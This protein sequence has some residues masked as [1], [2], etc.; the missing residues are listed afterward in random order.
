[1]K[2]LARA[3]LSGYEPGRWRA[4]ARV[5]AAAGAQGVKEQNVD[6]ED[7]RFVAWKVDLLVTFVLE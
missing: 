1:M 3:T 6:I 7:G 5:P 4:G 2:A